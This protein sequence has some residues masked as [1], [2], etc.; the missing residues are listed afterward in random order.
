M[1]RLFKNPLSCNVKHVKKDGNIQYNELYCSNAKSEMWPCYSHGGLHQISLTVIKILTVD[2]KT[3]E[4]SKTT[5][6]QKQRLSS[7]HSVLH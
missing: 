3:R 6:C 1:S 2:L 7:F 5:T 4:T